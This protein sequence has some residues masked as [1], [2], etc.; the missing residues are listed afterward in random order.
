[1]EL[2]RAA[3]LTVSDL[4]STVERYSTWLDY[5]PVETGT[6]ASDLAASWGCPD[7]ASQRYAIMQ[8]A[9]G[10]AVFIR[11]V[12]GAQ[13]AD[14]CPLRTYGWS[15]IELCVTDVLTVQDRMARSPFTI[16]GP[17]AKNPSLP[18]IFPMQVRGP[19]D[20]IVYLTQILSD[21]PQY[22]LP[23]AKSLIDRIF[24]MVLGCSDMRA[25]GRWFEANLGLALGRDIDI[26]YTMLTNAFGTPADQKFTICT[27][28][29]ERDVF[30]ELD[31]Y[32]VQAT[33]RPQQAGTLPPG[34]AIASF[35]NPDFDSVQADWITPPTR[36]AGPLYNG[37]RVGTVQAPDGTLVEMIEAA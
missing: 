3:T 34:I 7:S 6:I 12:E 36:R 2:L 14:Y 4:D 1:M 29:H 24:I 20:E 33:A 37:A 9:S 26:N 10:S 11:L 23:R 19:D 32:P 22:D 15:T 35:L 5:R 30:L 28:T 25:S 21:L 27:M 31:Q 17:A 13:V 18:T 8:P 16:I